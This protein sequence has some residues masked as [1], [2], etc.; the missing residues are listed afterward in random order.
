MPEGP[1]PAVTR[2]RPG[3]PGTQSFDVASPAHASWLGAQLGELLDFA[4]AAADWRDGGFD[5]L[6]GSGS[7]GPSGCTPRPG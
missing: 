2:E 6:T 4:A 7:P 5:G 3:P 1:G